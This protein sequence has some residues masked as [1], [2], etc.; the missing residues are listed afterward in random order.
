MEFPADTD[1][2][3]VAFT[4]HIDNDNVVHHMFVFG[5]RDDSEYQNPF[6]LH[7][8][9][10]LSNPKAFVHDKSNVAQIVAVVFD[11]LENVGKGGSACS[12][13]ITMFSPFTTMFSKDFH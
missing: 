12:P 10:D 1:Y 7:R 4:P 6:P 3:V 13:I 8:I 11:R 2:H 9:L 5:C